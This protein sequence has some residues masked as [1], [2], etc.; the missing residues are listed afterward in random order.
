MVCALCVQHMVVQKEES[1]QEVTQKWRHDRY[2][3]NFLFIVLFY[4]H[5]TFVNGLKKLIEGNISSL[6]FFHVLKRRKI[7][8]VEK[9]LK[10]CFV[11]IFSSCT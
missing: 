8:A 9:S 4:Q 3:F 2:Y 11:F 5:Q 10:Y 6:N 7:V 1:A